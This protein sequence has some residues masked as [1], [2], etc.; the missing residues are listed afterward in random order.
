M[1]R[2][3]RFAV[4]GV[5]GY[6]RSH[7]ASVNKLAEEGR[8]KLV[9]SMMIDRAD[10]PDL[11]ARFEADGVQVLDDYSAMLDACQGEVDVVTLPVPIHLHAP[12]TIA[13]LRAGYHVLVEKP[14]AGSL[15]EVDEMIAARDASGRQCAVGFQALYGPVFQTLKKYVAAGKLGRV[16]RI[17][18]MALWPRDPAYYGRNRW[19]GKLYCD[20]RPVFDSPFN[21]ALA[22]QVMNMLFLASPR[23]GEAAYAERVEAELWRAYDIESFDTGCL[24]VH[25]DSGVEVLF[26]ASHACGTTVDPLIQLEAD[27]AT[28]HYQYEGDAVITYADGTVEVMERGEGARNDVFRNVCD[29]VSGTVGQLACTLEIA[30]AHTACIEKMHQVAPIVDVPET[31]VSTIEGEQ[32]VIRG[33]ELAVQQSFSSGR[34][35]SELDEPPAGLVHAVPG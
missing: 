32:R 12:M 4:V 5:T 1:T 35:F 23:P 21:N 8:G 13:A 28:V 11:V 17:R 2:L 27:G 3:I 9:V 24:R 29:V 34:L 30:R 16:R 7:L 14:A 31:W 26:V 10:H 22:H 25:T 33:I 18:G 20:G 6:S 19:A 15:A